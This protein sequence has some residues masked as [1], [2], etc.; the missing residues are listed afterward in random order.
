MTDE[1]ETVSVTGDGDLGTVIVDRP[2]AM[3][4]VNLTV[5]EELS[6]A[7]ESAAESYNAL[8]LTGAGSD[9]FI[10]GG[11]IKEFKDASGVWFQRGFR[12]AMSDVEA[13]IEGSRVPVVAGVNGVALGGGTEIALMCDLI[14]AAESARFGLPEIGLGIIPGSGGTQRLT[15]LVGYLQAKEMILTGKHVPAPEAEEM[16]LVNEVVS[17]EDLEAR[18]EELGGELADGPLTANWFAKKAVNDARPEL[19]SGLELEAALA[20]LTFET[21]DKMEGMEAFVEKRE[22]EFRDEWE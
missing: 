19:D 13:A 18:L 16:G 6:T 21:E 10:G 12:E 14:V 1:F 8:I 15:H 7:L 4:A 11:D 2:E 3:N 20:A 9:A 5:L 22:P 17:D